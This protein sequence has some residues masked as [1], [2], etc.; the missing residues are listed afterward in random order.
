VINTVLPSVGCGGLSKILPPRLQFRAVASCVVVPE[1]LFAISLRSARFFLCSFQ[2]HP[3]VSD[4]E[5]ISALSKCRQAEEKDT[6]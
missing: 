5:L 1:Q 4:D 3:A 6:G 2:Q